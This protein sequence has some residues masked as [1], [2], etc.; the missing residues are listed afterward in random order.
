MSYQVA[1]PYA[2]ALFELAQDKG[3]TEQVAGD[4]Q[5]FQE[6]LDAVPELREV[7]FSVQ[8]ATALKKQVL[9]KVLDGQYQTI[10]RHFLLLLVDKGREGAWNEIR[11]LFQKHVDEAANVEEAIVI[12]AVELDE[13]LKEK[14]ARRLE[15][16]IGRKLRLTTQVDP[17]I[18]GGVVVRIGNRV[19]DGSFSGKLSRFSKLLSQ[20]QIG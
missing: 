2:N 19:Y 20:A 3:L 7:F 13:A 16:L 15:Q 18:L 11:A 8:Y 14:L 10:T 17:S 1:K 12:T 6:A 9:E 4:L 5:R